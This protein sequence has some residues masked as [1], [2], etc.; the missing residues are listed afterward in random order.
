MPSQSGV[1]D[2]P[3]NRPPVSH[4]FYQNMRGYGDQQILKCCSNNAV[5]P[6]RA[7]YNQADKGSDAR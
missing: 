7:A 5:E 6:L 4:A 3:Q 1:F 2:I